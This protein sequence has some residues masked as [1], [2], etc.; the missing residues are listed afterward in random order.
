MKMVVLVENSSRCRLCAEHGLS[1]YI[2][3]EG[4][5][6]LLDTGATALF[7]ENAKELGIDL[8]KVD[9]AFLSHAHYDHSGGFEEF[10]K[11][12]D[13]AAVY[14]QETSA[15]NCFYRTE[16]KDKYIGIPQHLLE[17]YKERFR[18]L[19]AVC[20]VE[21]GV[22]VVPH[23]TGGLDEMGRRAHMY[24]KIGE[25]FIADDF[26]HEQS[27][28]FETGKGLVIFNSCSHGGIVNIVREVQMALGGQKVYD[29]AFGHG[30]TCHTGGR[31]CGNCAGIE[32][33]WRRGNLYRS[34]Y[35]KYCIRDS[36]KRT[37][38][39]GTCTWNRG[40]GDIL[41]EGSP[42]IYHG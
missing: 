3:Y 31:G 4:K 28:V 18:P 10:F 16:G 11:E 42:R 29:E 40:N 27:V 36:E 35:R 38:R 39:N 9:T 37:W 21:K 17:N 12:N 2:E 30:Y 24:R 34:L 26:A 5:T 41:N 23:F 25:E 8:S 14:M 7:A 32:R 1:V 19:N 15:E 13:K 33:A 20:E 22:W 6:Y